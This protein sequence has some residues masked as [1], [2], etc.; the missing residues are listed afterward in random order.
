[1]AGADPSVLQHCSGS[2][3]RHLPDVREE[4]DDVL[5]KGLRPRIDGCRHEHRDR[6]L[7]PRALPGIEMCKVVAR[8]VGSILD[9][10]ER[11]GGAFD[12]TARS[13]ERQRTRS[14]V[15][16]IY[17]GRSIDSRSTTLKKSCAHSG[18]SEMS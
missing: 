8:V 14:S 9:R 13:V 4:V 15:L 1:M 6:R 7:K 12:V 3:F 18:W 5:K 16:S 2:R 17:S 11:L 10:A